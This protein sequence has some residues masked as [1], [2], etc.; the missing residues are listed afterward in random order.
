[1]GERLTVEI[2][3]DLKK[4]LLRYC[5]TSSESPSAVVD[6]A[7][8]EFIAKT[9]GTGEEKWFGLPAED[10]LAL[11]EEKREALWKRAYEV[12]L[13][14]PQPPE[15]ETHSRVATSRQ[16]GRETLRRRSREIREKS[17]THS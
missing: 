17:A 4:A 11:A 10:Y 5:E 15:R 7:L 3:K 12:E 16:R 13:D 2:G 14:K 9:R 1:M 6:R 8:K